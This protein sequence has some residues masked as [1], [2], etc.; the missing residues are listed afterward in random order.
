[1]LDLGLPALQGRD[2]ARELAAHELA[3]DIPISDLLDRERAKEP[4]HSN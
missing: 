4:R 3:R 2:V 1:V